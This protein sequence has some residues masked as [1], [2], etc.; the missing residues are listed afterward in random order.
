MNLP[1]HFW[2]DPGDDGPPAGREGLTSTSGRRL[3][4]QARNDLAEK[5]FD[6]QGGPADVSKVYLEPTNRCNLA[7][8]TCVRNNWDV[9]MGDMSAATFER[10]LGGIEGFASPPTVFFGGL[11][12]PLAHPRI[13]KMV[14]AAKAIGAEVELITNGTLLHEERSRQLIQAGL[15]VLWVSIDGSTPDRYADV[16]LGAAL[17]EVLENLTAFRRARTTSH[18]PKPEIG[19]VFVAMRRNIEDLPGVLALGRRRGATRF[20]VTNLLPHT[21]E[22][23]A[24]TLYE[25]SLKDIRYLPSN[26]VPHVSLP[27]IDLDR[28]TAPALYQVLRG[29]Y[30]ITFVGNN[31]GAAND[32]CPF[33]ADNT[34]TVGWDGGVSPCIPL[35]YPHDSFL[36]GQRRRVHSYRVGDV[37]DRSLSEVWN[38]P[39]YRSF[40]ARVK[41]FVFAPCTFCGGCDLAEANLSDCMGNAFPTCGGCLWSQGVIRCP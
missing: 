23:C 30:N 8:R 1:T 36:H 22:M 3:P 9:E 41:D 33:I 15:D 28:I 10:I 19:I 14:S 38:Q 16:R 27:K 39:D 20:I 4:G 12:E 21:P 29:G 37:R 5:A 35:L 6:P 31:L 34:L 17:P 40:R 18:R 13:V 26:W 32:S 24:E 7:C 11:G 2:N 25:S